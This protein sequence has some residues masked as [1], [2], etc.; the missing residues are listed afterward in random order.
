MCGVWCVCRREV[1]RKNLK[2]LVG[3]NLLRSHLWVTARYCPTVS[4]QSGTVMARV[5]VFV[6]RL[7]ELE[8]LS[9]QQYQTLVLPPLLVTLA[10]TLALTILFSLTPSAHHPVFL[11]CLVSLYPLGSSSC[12]PL[13]SS[14]FIPL[15]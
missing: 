6:F 7:S 10:L 15:G 12:F 5:C 1:Q 9:V 4:T 2:Q 11:N 3:A 13:L 14:Q 8:N